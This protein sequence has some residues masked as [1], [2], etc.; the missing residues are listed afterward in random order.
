EKLGVRSSWNGHR[1]MNRPLPPFRSCVRAETTSTKSAP[2][3]TASTELSAIR[4][5]RSLLE[6]LGICERKPIGH[7]RDEL[8]DLRKRAATL[9]KTVDDRAHDHVRP[10]VPRRSLGAE[11]HMLEHERAQ[12]EHSAADLVALGD[13]TRLRGRLDEIVYER[14]DAARTSRS[15]H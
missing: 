9:L 15:E 7:A 13:V 8:D 12:R 1:P 6:P 4:G 2:A 14:V 5:T 10:F 3:L 11:I